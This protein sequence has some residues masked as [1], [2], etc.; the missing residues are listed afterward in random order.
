MTAL[1]TPPVLY[2]FRR[3]PYAMRARLSIAYAQVD[4]ELREVVLRDKPES[5]RAYSAKATVPVLVL[6]QQHVIDESLD[7]I[8]WALSKNDPFNWL[9]GLSPE[10]Q[11]EAKQLIAENDSTFKVCLD[12]Y[13][14]ADR[15]PEKTVVEYRD[16][17]EAFLAKLDS[18]CAT[19]KYLLTDNISFADV[20]IFPFIRQF[21]FVDKVWFDQTPYGHLQAW[22]AQWLQSELFESV[23]RKYPMWVEGDQPTL[24]PD[25]I[26]QQH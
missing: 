25:H 8:Y 26:S 10:Q 14:Y 22:L 18:R 20:A 6:S 1:F 12:R 7:I 21:A 23:M 5:L 9:S 4:V 24:F 15:Y 11:N 16:E 2:S 3:C 17:G 13:K 19:S